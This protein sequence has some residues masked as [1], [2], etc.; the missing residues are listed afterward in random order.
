MR[1]LPETMES[2]LA[3]T[4]TD[5][6]V[7]VVND[8]STDEI[9]GWMLQQTD[10][11]LRVISQKNQGQAAARNTG[12]ADAEGEYIAFLDADDLWEANK[13][14]K[15]VSYLDA[16][17]EVGLVYTWLAM[18]D[19]ACRPTGRVA[20]S[21]AEGDVWE[22]IVEFNM[23]GCGSTPVVRRNCFDVV[24]HF[25]P[26]LSPSEDWDMWIRIAAQFPFGVIQEPLVLYRQHLESSSSQCQLML[27]TSSA[28]IERAFAAK[29]GFL[30]LKQR[31]Y[32]SLNLY[33]GWKALRNMDFGQADRFHQQAIAHYPSLRFSPTSIRLGLGITLMR[34]FGSD[35][36]TTL[37]TSLYTLRR[38][39]KQLTQKP[40][41]LKSKSF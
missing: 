22:R 35:A 29:T 34:W 15:Q 9:I 13:L 6:E 41:A 12:I 39:L 23:V 1:Y 40:S 10:S 26:E 38:F 2:V 27:E 36:Y 5:F 21:N 31:S 28:V 4:Y 14:E 25:I 20:S 18:A 3:Q 32:G 24:G 16:H 37:L 33:L 7:L 19:Q 11:R 8:G 17:S 30:H